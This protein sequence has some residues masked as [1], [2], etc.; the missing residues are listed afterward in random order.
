MCVLVLTEI[1]ISNPFIGTVE[2]KKNVGTTSSLYVCMY[3]CMYVCVCV[4][5]F[6]IN[7]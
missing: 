7:L 2:N 6:P 1:F 4:C 5:V 3:V